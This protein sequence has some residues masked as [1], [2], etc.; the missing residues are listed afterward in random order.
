MMEEGQ[1]VLEAYRELVRLMGGGKKE[2]NL[3]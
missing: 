3:C 1:R 2:V